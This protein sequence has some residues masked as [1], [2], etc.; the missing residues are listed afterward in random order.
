MAVGM[1][2]GWVGTMMELI[3]NLVFSLKSKMPMRYYILVE[4]SKE[5]WEGYNFDCLG[6]KTC[7]VH[8]LYLENKC[9]CTAGN[10]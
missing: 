5:G 4:L 1:F 7:T 10:K 8:A 2:A 3:L 9:T 6:I